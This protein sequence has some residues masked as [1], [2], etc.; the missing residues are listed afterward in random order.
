MECLAPIL[1]FVLIMA[2]VIA[3]FRKEQELARRRAMQA[4]AAPPAPPRPW[5]GPQAG[6]R[7]PPPPPW[8]RPFLEDDDVEEEPPDEAPWEDEEEEPAP[9]RQVPPPAMPPP[10]WS[11]PEEA[12]VEIEAV[13]PAAVA[14]PASPRRRH[15]LR[16]DRTR[17]RDAVVLVEVLGPPVAMRA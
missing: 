3:R 5:Q 9:P 14:R 1:I 6:P 8:M 10:R 16:L 17:L 4:P 13:L 15:R 7:Q 2:Q 11:L 12:H